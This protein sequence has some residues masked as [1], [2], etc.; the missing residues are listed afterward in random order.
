MES[1]VNN[2]NANSWAKQA[3][4]SSIKGYFEIDN[5]YLMGKL[6]HIIF[7]FMSRVEQSKPD[8]QPIE[9]QNSSQTDNSIFRSDL[10]IPLMSFVT[11]IL[12]SCLSLGL[13]K[14]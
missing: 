14:K 11:Y 12:L 7:P 3:F 13:E 9:L 10:Y 4:N 8:I 6:R 5:S 2:I 1:S